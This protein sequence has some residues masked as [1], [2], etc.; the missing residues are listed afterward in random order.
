MEM[1]KR[2]LGEEHLNTLTSMDNIAFTYNKQ[3]RW[4]EAEV[5]YVQ[6]METKKKV[7]GKEHLSTLTSMGLTAATY[8]KQ[9]RWKEAEVLTLQ[10]METR[11]RLRDAAYL[12]RYLFVQWNHKRY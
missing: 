4:D 6:V 5:L 8:A 12:Q 1:R 3:E 2:E 9:G 7:L 10:V 11:K